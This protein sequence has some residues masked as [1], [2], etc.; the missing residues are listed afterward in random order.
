M[1]HR[2]LAIEVPRPPLVHVLLATIAI[3][4]TLICA[5]KQTRV[6]N[7][8]PVVSLAPDKGFAER[9]LVPGTGNVIVPF[10]HP[11]MQQ[12]PRGMVIKPPDTGDRI[13]LIQPSPLDIVLSTLGLPWLVATTSEAAALL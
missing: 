13:N 4:P 11:D 10:D 12:W 8:G 9:H 2:A 7:A 6:S 1:T 3:A 5:P